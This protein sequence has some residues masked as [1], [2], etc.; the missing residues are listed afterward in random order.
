MITKTIPNRDGAAKT[1]YRVREKVSTAAMNRVQW[2]A[3]L[4]ELS[5]INTR[6][7][8]IMLQGGKRMGEVLSLKTK[9]IS[10]ANNE[11][12]FLQS[13]TKGYEKETII[14]YPQIIFDE[15]ETY[16]GKREDFVFVTKNN[17]SVMP[18]QI[19]ITF[20]KAGARA[21]IPFNVTP[22][23]L[24]ASTVTYLKREGFSDG[25]I[26]KVTGHASAEMV[27]AYDKSERAENATKRVSLV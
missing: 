2:Q 10:Y 27:Y 14:T 19:A 15:L 8:L 22:H 17:K 3:F 5:K 26:M 11:I 20:K 9:R 13:K 6:D 21:Q 24:R 12:S 18:N 16:I 25:E 4:A 23:V 7:T 1:F